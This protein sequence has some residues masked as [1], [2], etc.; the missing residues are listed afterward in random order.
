MPIIIGTITRGPTREAEGLIRT[1]GSA[2]AWTCCRGAA[3]SLER[4]SLS[5][6]LCYTPRTHPPASVSP[7][8]HPLHPPQ[9]A[10]PAWGPRDPPTRGLLGSKGHLDAEPCSQL[11]QAGRSG[12]STKG[13]PFAQ[14]A[15]SKSQAKW[16]YASPERRKLIPTSLE[17][18]GHNREEQRAGCHLPIGVGA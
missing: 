11:P 18:P 6:Q 1:P 15:G 13:T 9:D 8:D 7:Q 5:C 17:S 10:D 14:N 2:G 3:A 4:C 12:G 16:E